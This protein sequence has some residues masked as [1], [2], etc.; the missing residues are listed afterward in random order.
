MSVEQALRHAAVL[1]VIILQ[2]GPAERMQAAEPE[3][4]PVHPDLQYINTRFENASPLW[5]ETDADRAI[6]I[7]L[8]YDRE[9]SSP[10]RANGHWF[11]ELQA[12]A[13]ADLTLVLQPFDNVWNGKLGSPIAEKTISFISRDGK[14]WEPIVGER[15]EGN[16]F[17]LQ[18]HMDGPSLYVARLEPYRLSDLEELKREIAS[19]QLVEIMEIGR[20]VEDRPLEI[21]RVGDPNVPHH[22]LL[23]ARSHPWEPGGSWVVQGLIRRLLRDGKSARRCLERCCVWI[24]PM[25]NKDG[26]ARGRTRFN[27][28]GKD[29]NR[30][31]GRPADPQLAPENHAL[32]TWLEEMI[33]AGRRPDL[34]IDLH[35][36]NSGKL[37]VSRPEGEHEAYFAK[38]ERLEALLRAHTWFTEGST[39]RGFRNPGTI[40]EGL[41]ERYGIT[42]CVLELNANWIAGLDDYPSGAHWERFGAGL[43]DVFFAYFE[44]KP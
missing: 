30:D 33:A 44:P 39:G 24:L 12:T 17:R 28:S 7:H 35:N 40:G 4:V 13:G 22:V 11:F 23:R 34:A 42:A 43:A 10:N 6:Q 14:D 31:W 26:V 2:F 32:E 15:L 25:A 21:I 18:V 29:L 20:T 8:V 3:R 19:H 41:L 36:D 5:W 38:M 27:M 16:R 9:R 1:G 37:H